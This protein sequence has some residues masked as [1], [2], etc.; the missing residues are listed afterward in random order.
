MAESNGLFGG[1]SKSKVIETQNLRIHG[2]LLRW[3][4]TAIQISN[5]AMV[6]TA[7]LPL[8]AFPVWAVL[9]VIGGVIVLGDRQLGGGGLIF[10]AIGVALGYFWYRKYK[11]V[12]DMRYLHIF[13]NS[14]YTYSFLFTNQDFMSQVLQVFANIFESGMKSD[15]N[16]LINAQGNEIRENGAVVSLNV[17]R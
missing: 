1:D 10:I 11:K 6:S 3:S 13:L 8:P 4:D 7:E 15:T 5:I 14:G 17:E 9:F 12:K 2:Q 16:I